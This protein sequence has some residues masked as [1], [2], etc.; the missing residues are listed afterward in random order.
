M[1]GSEATTSDVTDIISTNLDSGDIDNALTYAKDL[2][3]EYN[4]EANQTATQTKYIEVWGAIAH[5]RQHLERSVERDSTAASSATFEGDE[6]ATAK[7]QLR[8]WLERAGG[9]L[10]MVDAFDTIR[11]DSS[12]SVGTSPQ[13]DSTQSDAANN[14]TSSD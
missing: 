3:Q 1:A 8:S 9:D 14:V 10:A 5:I 6:L 2:N 11:R 7:A 13:S 12:R 4:D